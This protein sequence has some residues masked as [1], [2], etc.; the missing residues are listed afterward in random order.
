VDG[1]KVTSFGG[2]QSHTTR[3]TNGKENN[4]LG[5]RSNKEK[6]FISKSQRVQRLGARISPLVPKELTSG[7][8]RRRTSLFSVPLQGAKRRAF[9]VVQKER[10]T[11]VAQT[12]CN[13]LGTTDML[14]VGGRRTVLRDSQQRE[15]S[16][17]DLTAYR[18]EDRKLSF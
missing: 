5:Y 13:M 12:G 1:E 15:D 4:R 8:I 17:K 7:H 14:S 10:V 6:I 11:Q 3:M 2:Q 18:S 9:F 16:K